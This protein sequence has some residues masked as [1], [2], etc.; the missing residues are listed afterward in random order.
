MVL[1]PKL[2]IHIIEKWQSLTSDNFTFFNTTHLIPLFIKADILF[3]DTTSA[4]QEFVLQKKPVVTFKHKVHEDFL[5]NIEDSGSIEAAFK[6]AL[7]PSKKLLKK[8]DTYVQNLHPYVDGKSSK[9]VIDA[10]I[11]FLQKDRSYLN[12]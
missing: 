8:I 12:T 9:R 11:S 10:C 4:I 6:T 5:I 3:A 7:N 1:H 2:P